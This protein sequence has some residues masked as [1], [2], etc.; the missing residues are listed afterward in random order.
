MG[1]SVENYIVFSFIH[2][3]VP[4]RFLICI[5]DLVLVILILLR[6]EVCRVETFLSL[7]FLPIIYINSNARKSVIGFYINGTF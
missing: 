3:P 4:W 6:L 5:I 1:A 2:S 7:K